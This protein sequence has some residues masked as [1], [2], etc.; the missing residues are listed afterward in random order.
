MTSASYYASSSN[1]TIQRNDTTLGH[2][3]NHLRALGRSAVCMWPVLGT[4]TV[5]FAAAVPLNGSDAGLIVHVAPAA[6][7]ANLP[8]LRTRSS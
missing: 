4:V 3:P 6:A 5:A 7:L 8:W 2:P 1:D